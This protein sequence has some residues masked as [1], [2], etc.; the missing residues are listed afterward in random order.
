MKL[1]YNYIPKAFLRN[2]QNKTN[3]SSELQIPCD[4]SQL[5]YKLYIKNQK[6]VLA[7]IHQDQSHLH[8]PLD[9]FLASLATQQP[10]FEGTVPSLSLSLWLWLS[11][12]HSEVGLT[13]LV[14]IS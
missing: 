3:C 7:L 14:P 13:V 8:L 5:V 4:K 11:S 6:V 2:E 9:S 1:N 12:S 10:S